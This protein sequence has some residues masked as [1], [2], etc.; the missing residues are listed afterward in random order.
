MVEVVLGIIRGA[1]SL[2]KPFRVDSALGKILL[3]LVPM[4]HHEV[5]LEAGLVKVALLAPLENAVKLLTLHLV[6]VDLLVLLQV[7]ARAE[8]FI[9]EFALERL[10]SRVNPLVSDQV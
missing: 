8:P 1:I 10:F 7:G 9:A 6:A 5:L 3:V 2:L 4:R